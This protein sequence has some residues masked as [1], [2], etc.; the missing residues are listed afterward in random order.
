MGCMCTK[1]AG[2]SKIVMGLLLLLNGFLWP[3]WQGID[4]WIKWIAVLMVVGGA[5]KLL[6]PNKCKTCNAMAKKK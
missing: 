3:M 5:V 4:G 2:T 1:C 6:V